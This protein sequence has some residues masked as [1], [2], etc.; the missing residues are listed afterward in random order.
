MRVAYHGAGGIFFRKN[1]EK[2][3]MLVYIKNEGLT[4]DGKAG[5]ATMTILAGR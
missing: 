5:L 1:F 4:A 3:E 2:S